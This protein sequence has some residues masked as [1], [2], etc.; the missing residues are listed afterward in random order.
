MDVMYLH[1]RFPV[2]LYTNARACVHLQKCQLCGMKRVCVCV[3]VLQLHVFI[4]VN[5]VY[6]R[7]YHIILCATHEDHLDASTR[8]RNWGDTGTRGTVLSSTPPQVTR[9]VSVCVCVC[10]RVRY[11]YAKRLI[12][13]RKKNKSNS[14]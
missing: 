8:R 9:G 1:V 7:Y 11:S 10:V 13:Q 12:G 6:T 3:S 14:I 2:C 4:S 5:S